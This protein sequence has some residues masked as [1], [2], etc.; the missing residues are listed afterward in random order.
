MIGDDVAVDDLRVA[1]LPELAGQ[2]AL[3][4][5]LDRT[6]RAGAADQVLAV[7]VVRALAHAGNY[8]AGAWR[9]ERLVGGTV[10]FLGTGHLHSHVTAVDPGT[11]GRGVGHA[12]KLHQREWAL[13][14]GITDVR[15]TFDPL[16]GRNA[17]FNIT[18]LGAEPTAYLTDFYGPLTD[19][20]NAGDETDRLYV[21]WD[22][23]ASRR[24]AEAEPAA[25]VPVLG[26]S[27]DDRPLSTV[28][29]PGGSPALVAT[30]TDI[31]ALRGR[32]PD[33][34]RAW[35]LAVRAALT[36]LLADGYRVTGFRRDGFYI[37]EAR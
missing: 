31:E 33:A 15:W 19:G 29:P 7:D 26:R 10:A 14:R 18:K 34:A 4:A 28:P 36:T 37:L 20:V 24:A 25:A 3:V 12:L 5:L 23:T 17:Y 22:L 21:R 35:R 2:R 6:F 30:P 11:H 13:A 16:V 9:G 27:A 32:D 8:V 1:N